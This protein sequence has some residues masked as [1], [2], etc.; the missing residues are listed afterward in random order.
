VIVL[1]AGPTPDARKVS[2]MLEETG[3]AYEIVRRE[4]APS[5]EDD[6]VPLELADAS[7]ILV[8]LAERS[9]RLFPVERRYRYPT[10]QWLMFQ[11]RDGERLAAALDRRLDDAGYLACVYSIADIAAYPL[12]MRH[13][14]SGL[15]LAAYPALSR[16]AHAIGARRAVQRGM[17][18]L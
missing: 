9:G 18:A 11:E 10:L 12:V 3:L 1:Y 8:Y 15:A 17:A 5:I 7:A 16:W 6:E 2:I 13:A 14:E 4:Q